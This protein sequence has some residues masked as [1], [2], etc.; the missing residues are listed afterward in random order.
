MSIEDP[1]ESMFINRNIEIMQDGIKSF[2]IGMH[3]SHMG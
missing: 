1:I 2:W 3:R